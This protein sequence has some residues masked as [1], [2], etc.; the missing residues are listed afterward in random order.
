MKSLEQILTETYGH[1]HILKENGD[2]TEVGYKDM[3]KLET[4]LADLELLGLPI[5]APKCIRELDKIISEP[6]Y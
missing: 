6:T 2:L 4:L 1:K 5:D 3:R